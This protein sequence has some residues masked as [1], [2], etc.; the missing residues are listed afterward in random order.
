MSGMTAPV[1]GG[2]TIYRQDGSRQR[3]SRLRLASL[4][5]VA[6]IAGAGALVN[7]IQAHPALQGSGRAVDAASTS[8]FSYFPR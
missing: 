3:R 8:P 4:L 2:L 6:V 1:V 7:A 5:T